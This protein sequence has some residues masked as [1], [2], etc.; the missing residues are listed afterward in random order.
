MTA[1]YTISHSV[2][3]PF[4]CA[5]LRGRNVYI[6]GGLDIAAVIIAGEGE[7][8]GAFSRRAPL[9]DPAKPVLLFDTL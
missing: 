7:G 6:A 1:L 8:V 3:T 5:G 2:S 4:D 9:L